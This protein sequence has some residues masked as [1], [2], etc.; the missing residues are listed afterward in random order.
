M[1]S[2][3]HQ[4]KAK[5]RSEQDFC[6]MTHL[7]PTLTNNSVNYSILKF[8][9]AKINSM[10]S[11][12]EDDEYEQRFFENKE[13]FQDMGQASEDQV[14][15]K[16]SNR[17]AGAADPR[18]GGTVT[19]HDY[20]LESFTDKSME[21]HITH[22][23]N[24]PTTVNMNLINSDSY[25]SLCNIDSIEERKTRSKSNIGERELDFKNSFHEWG[26]TFISQTK[27]YIKDVEKLSEQE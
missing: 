15:E 9:V 21:P 1:L 6:P 11:Y 3:S 20:E 27:I 25:T 13:L 7:L 22:V 2:S 19:P 24:L 5:S 18:T 26:S 10:N 16:R 4:K 8:I 12:L 14:E 17:W 23:N